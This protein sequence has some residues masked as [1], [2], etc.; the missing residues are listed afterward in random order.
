MI[1]NTEFNNNFNLKLKSIAHRIISHQND[2]TDD[3]EVIRNKIIK[4]LIYCKNNKDNLNV[5]QI[6]TVLALLKYEFNYLQGFL[7]YSKWKH[8]FDEYLEDVVI[9]QHK[10]EVKN[11]LEQNINKPTFYETFS[12]DKE[13][14]CSIM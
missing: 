7:S 4:F 13:G 5:D 11:K 2:L 8:Y 9:N 10:N 1:A 14:Y 6:E 12:K 3:V